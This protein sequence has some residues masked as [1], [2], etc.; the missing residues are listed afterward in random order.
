MYADSITDSMRATIDETNR[1]REKQIKYNEEHGIVPRTVGKSRE[2]IM[3]QT[4]VADFKG[5]AAKAYV[6][7]DPASS[8]AADPVV[9]YMSKAQ[10]QKAIDTAKRD[11]ERA[12]K[13]M[14]FLQA[15]K[16]RDE[17]FALE[18]TMKEKF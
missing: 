5:G 1:R 4:S 12:A 2:A 10:L 11:M 15:A 14:D 3:E 18:K 13:D 16:L 7:P 9:Q 6:D 17:M 8:V